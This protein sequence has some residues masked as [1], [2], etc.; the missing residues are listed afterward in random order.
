MFVASVF[1]VVIVK[2][3]FNLLVAIYALL[4]GHNFG[5]AIIIFTVVIRLLMW[6]LVK[7]QLHHAKAMRDLQPE[8]KRIKK[9]TKG[10]RQKES[11][12]LMEL[13]KERQINPFGSFGIIIIQLVILIGLY[14]GLRKVVSD[15]QALID[16]S[17]GW[18]HNTA[19]LK[20]LASNIGQFDATLLGFVDLSKA[21]L[22]KGGGIYWPAMMLVAGSAVAQYYQSKQ[23]MP[24][25]KDARSLR[26]I[27]R[28][29]GQGKQAEQ[30]EINAAIARG[31]RFLIPGMIFLF[32]VSIPAAL[33]LYWL[34]SGVVAIWQQ[35]RILKQDET[36]MEAI[37]DKPDKQIIEG[38]VIEKP[39]PKSKNKKSPAK[40][41]R[42]KKK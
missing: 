21:A 29:A 20:S 30:G 32:T 15:P 8:I 33:S 31:S 37:A 25:D 11:Q 4:P 10:D 27:L 3:L 35:G 6:P 14:S 19:W 26:T 13:Y 7:K 9:E 17:Y 12:L 34:T 41:K 38:E 40:R 28:E 39:K 18:L 5:V 42:R 2:P 1:E 24:S 16:F 23:L 22:P 36:E